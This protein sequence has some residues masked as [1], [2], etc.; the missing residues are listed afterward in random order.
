VTGSYSRTLLHGVG[1][2]VKQVLRFMPFAT[3]LPAYCLH[4]TW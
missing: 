4:C 1:K 3:Q 2:L